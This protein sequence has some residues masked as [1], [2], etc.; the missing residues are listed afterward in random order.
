VRLLGAG[1]CALTCEAYDTLRSAV[2][3]EADGSPRLA[4]PARV[5]LKIFHAHARDAGLRVRRA[6]AAPQTPSLPPRRRP[7]CGSWR[8]ATRAAPAA[9]RAWRACAARARAARTWC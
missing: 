7:R 2:P 9:A 8:G 1:A 3:F 5:A 4:A 6:R